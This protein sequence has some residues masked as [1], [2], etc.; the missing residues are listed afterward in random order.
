MTGDRLMMAIETGADTAAWGAARA[1]RDPR[2]IKRRGVLL[3]TAGFMIPFITGLPFV[4]RAGV[5]PVT[6]GEWLFTLSV[7]LGT[8]GLMWCL[9]LPG[10]DKLMSFDPNFLIVPSAASAI[11]LWLFVYMYPESRLVVLQGWFVVLL[12]GASLFSLKEVV[13]LNTFMVAGYLVTL[14]V[15]YA[16]GHPVSWP[17]EAGV[18]I[19][20]FVLFTF[21]CGTVLERLRRERVEMKA[22]RNQLSHLALTDRL[23]DLPNR[24]HF[25]D[26][27][28]HHSA[29]CLRSG[30]TYAVG[31][32]DVDHFKEIN[33]SQGHV[34]GDRVLVELAQIVRR[35]LRQSDLAARLGGDEFAVLFAGTNASEAGVVLNRILLAVSSHCFSDGGLARGQV[36]VSVGVTASGGEETPGDVLRR[37]DAELYTAKDSGRNRLVVGAARSLPEVPASEDPALRQ[38]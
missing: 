28:A 26:Y 2:S 16:G 19:F 1:T 34:V 20:P 23:T 3:G 37:A 21:F 4:G 27:S 11:L 13:A 9:L 24:R 18:V 31:L 6:W 7:V 30:A 14:G 10:F 32:I 29:L 22:L 5:V 38:G 36:T 8:W 35:H 33:D 12:F 25:D 17:F 15:L